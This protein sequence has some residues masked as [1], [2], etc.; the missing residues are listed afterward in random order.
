MT[1]IVVQPFYGP[2]VVHHPGCYTIRK[3]KDGQVAMFAPEDAVACAHCRA[4]E[5]KPKSENA[6]KKRRSAPVEHENLLEGISG[7]IVVR[8]H[9][10]DQ[11]AHHPS[12][13]MLWRLRATGLRSNHRVVARVPLGALKC[14][15]CKALPRATKK[16]VGTYYIEK[17]LLVPH[18][19]P[20]CS[21]GALDRMETGRGWFCYGCDWTG[22]V[23]SS[24]W[25]LT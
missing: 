11:I 5:P 10:G 18:Q 7:F 19:C 23:N 25:T 8:H 1:F 3:R 2:S 17:G 13:G 24:T 22:I 14:S 21:G 9:T 12:C 6:P 20:K 4:S 15:S 16:P